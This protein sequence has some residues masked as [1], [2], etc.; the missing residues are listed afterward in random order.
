M[1]LRRMEAVM[2]ESTRN[3][4]PNAPQNPPRSVL[5]KDVRR[6]ALW[7]YLTPLVLFFAGVAII[8]A[9]W[10]TSPPVRHDVEEPRVEGTS[11]TERA[12]SGEDTPG[13]HNPD[14]AISKPDREREHRGG[15]IITELGEVFEDSRDTIGRRVEILDVDVERVDSATL[16]WI[17]DGS[18]RAAVA[19]PTGATVHAGQSVNVIGAVE[20]TTEG[21]R[22]RASRVEPS[23]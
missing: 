12:R 9:Y 18:V 13:G 20:R 4:D 5:N 6:S 11:G 15:R 19:A 8:L 22:I 1:H 2:A 23:R 16:F 21:V 3:P 14:R 7:T 17:R 10:G